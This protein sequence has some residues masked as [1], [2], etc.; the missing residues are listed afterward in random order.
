M[1]FPARRFKAWRPKP[2]P[3]LSVFIEDARLVGGSATFTFNADFRG[4]EID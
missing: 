1:R 4:R 2:V 3:R